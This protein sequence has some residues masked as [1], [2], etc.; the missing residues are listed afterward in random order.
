MLFR[1]RTKFVAKIILVH[2]ALIVQKNLQ[3]KLKNFSVYFYKK[4]KECLIMIS[5]SEFCGFE[6]IESLIRIL[7]TSRGGFF[8][9][10][11]I[12]RKK[13]PIPW[14]KNPMGFSQKVWD[15]NPKK[16]PWD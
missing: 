10:F 6:Y 5:S 3:T 13:I 12:P 14:E 16:I 15:K 7:D 4:G 2:P 8:V 11:P 9:G 1:V